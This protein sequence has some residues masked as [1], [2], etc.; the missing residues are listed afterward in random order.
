[1]AKDLDIEE[2]RAVKENLSEDELAIFDLLLK[3]SLDPE[4]VS[5][6]KNASHELLTN[7]KPLLVPHWRDFET[8]R[9]GVKIVISELLFKKLPEPTYSEKECELKGLEIYN[10]VYEHYQDAR[11][12]VCA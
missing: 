2:Q 10:F 6:I 12:L 9:A 7:L 3:E 1:M 5:I 4:E 11:S 8:N